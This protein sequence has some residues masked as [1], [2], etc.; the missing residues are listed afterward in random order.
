VAGVRKLVTKGAQQMRRHTHD[1]HDALRGEPAEL[2][3]PLR[4]EPAQRQCGDM[5]A[6]PTLAG[7]LKHFAAIGPEVAR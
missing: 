4:A 6:E 3:D 2:A 7:W 1:V 5:V